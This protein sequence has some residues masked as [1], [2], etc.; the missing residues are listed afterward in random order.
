M[1]SVES[2]DF[3][4]FFERE[5]ERPL[6]RTTLLHKQCICNV[7]LRRQK[8]LTVKRE[9]LLLRSLCVWR[10]VSLGSIKVENVSQPNDKYMYQCNTLY[11]NVLNQN[12]EQFLNCVGAKM[13]WLFHHYRAMC[14]VVSRRRSPV[15][16]TWY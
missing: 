10:E 4:F 5:T 12:K 15:H 8:C 2:L 14:T 16:I 1:C 9:N 6:W 3:F 7:R 13:W 11:E